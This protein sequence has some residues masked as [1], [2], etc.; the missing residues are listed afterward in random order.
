MQW[1]KERKEIVRVA[2][3][4]YKKGLVTA[5][6]GNFSVRTANETILIT[7]RSKSYERL[8]FSDIIELNFDGKVI[9]GSREPSSEYR[10]HIEIYKERKDIN[11]VIHTHSTFACALAS[12]N[13]SLPVILDEQRA[14][15]GGEIRVAKYAVSGTEEL[16]KEAV[17]ALKNRKAV[18]LSRHGAVAVGKNISEA[19]AI[20][21]LIEKFCQIY[22]F[23]RL[24]QKQA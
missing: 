22:V 14:V 4:I 10:L 23:M 11:A 2:K 8:K 12:L 18:F 13:Q 1:E 6:S 17:K 19:D 20:C 21:E 7:P 15:F 3:K 9:E 16:A 24:L 5:N